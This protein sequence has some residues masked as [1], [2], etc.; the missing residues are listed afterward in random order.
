MA[1]VSQVRPSPLT[2]TGL[3][4]YLASV[5]V[6]ILAPSLLSPFAVIFTPPSLAS[7]IT[8]RFEIGADD[9]PF[10]FDLALLYFHV[11]KVLSAANIMVAVATRA[12]IRVSTVRMGFT[13]SAKISIPDF[14]ARPE[15]IPNCHLSGG[16]QV[17]K[18]PR[19]TGGGEVGLVW[20]R[21]RCYGIVRGTGCLPINRPHES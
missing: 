12:S 3:P 18:P 2:V 17:R 21:H 9:T 4:S 1:A 15:Y 11:P 6:S 16:P 7:L 10:L 14:L 5:T 8:I 20:F 19:C 13:P